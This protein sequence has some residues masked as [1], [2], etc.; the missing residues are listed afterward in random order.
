LVDTVESAAAAHPRHGHARRVLTW[1]P[2]V[3]LLLLALSL[4]LHGLAAKPLWLDEIATLHRATMTVHDLILSSLQARH[5]PSYFLLMWLV[6]KFGTSAWVLRLP[7]AIFGALDAALVYGIGCEIE[8]P[9]A[10]LAAG[11]LLALSPFAVQYSQEARSYTLV[12]SLILVALWGLVCLARDPAAAAARWHWRRMPLPWLAYI[13][14]TAAALNVLNVAVPWWIA[15]NLAALAIAHGMRDDR[16]GCKRFL[17]HWATAQAVIF[18]L[19][20]PALVAVSLVDKAGMLHGEGWAPP[21][22]PETIWSIVAPVY[23]DRITAFITFDVLPAKIPAVSFLIAAAA[24]YGAWRLRRQPIVLAVIGAAACVLPLVL[25]LIAL[26]TPILVPRY[27]AWSAAPFCV[28]AGLGLAQLAAQ[29]WAPVLGAIA[30]VCLVNL[31]PYY[32]DETKPRWDLAAQALAGESRPGDVVLVNDWNA[33]Q[34]IAAFAGPSG[35]AAQGI[36]LTSDA[37]DAARFAPGHNLWVV[38]GR[39][40]Q[41]PMP[42]PADYLA[43]LAPL[44]QPASEQDIGQYIVI[45]RFATSDALAACA[46]ASG[47]PA[48]RA[49]ATP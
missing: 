33:Y 2:A 13:A 3:A 41:G 35:L 39:A 21:E 29:R 20:L 23:L 8:G 44:G 17:R 30:A 42:K 6:A 26:V 14:G 40:G 49:L 45:W 34:L 25:L 48:E 38:Y 32:Q 16:A 9:V 46:A 31:A 10:G 15:A 7:S 1:L 12:A 18:L 43:R 47:C 24:L 19:W 27:F 4:R 5:Y 36:T 37:V 28:L 22:T 11:L